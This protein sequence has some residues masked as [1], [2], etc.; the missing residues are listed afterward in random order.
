MDG[1]RLQTAL[2]CAVELFFGPNEAR[3][4]STQR[5]RRTYTQ[6][7]A[8]LLRD[9][10]TLEVARCDLGRSVRNLNLVEQVFELV[11]VFGDVDGLDVD[12]DDL[13]SVLFPEALLISLNA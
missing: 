4:A 8:K 3:T 10:F 12:T 5:E 1:A 9:L 11:A 2:K 7:V 6:G 13:H